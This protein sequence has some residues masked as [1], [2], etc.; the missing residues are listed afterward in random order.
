MQLQFG[1]DLDPMFY[2]VRVSI[3]VSP[4]ARDLR[5]GRHHRVASVDRNITILQARE[6]VIGGPII[7]VFV[8]M[9]LLEPVAAVNTESFAKHGGDER[10]KC[11]EA[12]ADT[13]H[14]TFGRCPNK[15]IAN[16]P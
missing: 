16:T 10:P 9:G 5:L 6:G 14:A 4:L 2:I 8:S 3:R 1:R 7:A 15:G 13:T 12:D 11:W